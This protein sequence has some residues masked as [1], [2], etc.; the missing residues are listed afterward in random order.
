MIGGYTMTKTQEKRRESYHRQLK[1]CGFRSWTRANQRRGELIDKQ[2]L[3]EEESSE[4]EALQRLCDLYVKW[5]TNDQNGRLARRAKRLL[6]RV[7]PK[8]SN[9]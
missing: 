8:P 2:I 3:T 6:A 9:G 7:T 1:R 4:L 5:K